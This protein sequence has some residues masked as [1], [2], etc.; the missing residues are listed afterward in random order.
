MN[1]IDQLSISIAEGGFGINTDILDTN[2]INII[3]LLGAI[4]FLGKNSLGEALSER[5]KAILSSLQEA[6]NKLTQ[7]KVRLAEA[8]KQLST[9]SVSV[10]EVEEKA[11]KNANQLK[12]ALLKQGQL[13]IQRLTDNAKVTMVI[14]EAQVRQQILEQITALT[15]KRVSIQLK[16]VLNSDVQNQIIDKGIAD[17]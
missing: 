7:A 5:E 10:N 17:I 6:E 15:I 12:S 9:V 4:I 16:E 13:D 1:I 11:I 14:A 3:I 8:E 2:L